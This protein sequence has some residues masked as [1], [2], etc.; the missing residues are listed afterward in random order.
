[1][2]RAVPALKSSPKKI[3]TNFRPKRSASSAPPMV[4]PIR[5][6][7]DQMP[8]NNPTRHPDV[9]FLRDIEG[10]EWEK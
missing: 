6:L 2:N 5:L 4:L 8:N 9:K 3:I 7:S 1:M 10:E